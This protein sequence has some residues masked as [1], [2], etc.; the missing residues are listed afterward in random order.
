MEALALGFAAVV[1]GLAVSAVR[2]RS[3]VRACCP[4]PEADL[5]MRDAG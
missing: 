3:A 4:P 2:G 5:R 1:V